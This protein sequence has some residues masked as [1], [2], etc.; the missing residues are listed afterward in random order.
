M[1]SKAV[2]LLL[3][4]W[5]RPARADGPTDPP[6]KGGTR[7]EALSL[8]TGPGSLQGM[9]E[10]LNAEPSTGALTLTVP[11]ALPP[12]PHGFQ[13][14]LS[15][16]YASR[17]GNG[18]LGLGWS[19]AL[20][21]ISRRTDHGLP[22]YAE[23]RGPPNDELLWMGRRLIQVDAD[24]WRLRVEGEF[25]RIV[26]LG[27][28]AAGFRADRKDGSKIFLGTSAASQVAQGGRIFRWLPERALDPFGNE[29][30]YRYTWDEGQAY[31]EEVR[32]GTEGAPHARA[33]LTY[34]PRPDVQVDLRSGFAVATARRLV[35]IETFVGGD[36]GLPVRHVSL[37][38][39]AGPGVSRLASVQTC[40]FDRATC[41]PALTFG[42]TG[43]DPSLATL[44]NL[45]PP[46][47]TL[48]DPN[49]AL[50]DVDGDSLPDVVDLTEQGASVFRNLGPGGF[51]SGVALSGAPGVQLSSPGVAFQ[52]MD[53]DGHA[54]LLLA[55]GATGADGFAYL[56]AMG[57]GLGRSVAVAA[58]F[59]LPASAGQLRWIDL[60]GDGRVDAL[61]GQ[62]EGWTAW[63][64]L[65][66]GNFGDALPVRA[67]LAN[68][69]LDDAR[70]R[71][72]DMNDDG[73]VD[74]VLLQ[75]GSLQVMFNQ[76]FGNFS[77]PQAMS[78]VPDV[79]GDDQRLAL[80][81]ADGDGLPDLYY[82]APGRLLLWLNR[83]DGTFGTEVQARNAPSYDP[84][85]TTV[86][87][88][89]LLGN[90]T[91]G[92]VY[93]GSQDGKPFLWFF[94]PSSGQRPNL[95]AVID[96]G[97]GGKRIVSYQSTGQAMAAAAAAG[98]G[99]KSFTPFAQSIV[100]SVSLDDGVSPSE[101]E[102]RRYANPHYDGA[103]RLF[104]G[105]A[106]EARE[107]PQ[108]AHAAG[109]LEETLFHTGLNEDLSLVGSRVSHSQSTAAGVLLRR[110]TNEVVA[111]A[112]A[113]GLHGES[114]AFA[115]E[116]A[117]T[118][119][120]WEGAGRPLRERRRQSF[121]GHGNV[122]DRFDDGRIDGPPDPAADHHH[123]AF[124]EDTNQWM[125]GLPAVD[126][127]TDASGHRV[128]LE[129][130]YYDGDSCQGLPLGR[131]VRGAQ[132]RREGW[133]AEQGF[134]DVKR[135]ALDDHGN[136]IAW[137]DAD[138]RRVETDYDPILHQFPVEE[139]HFA[140][141]GGTPLRFG[142]AVDPAIGQPLWFRDA[143]GALTRYGWD[144]LGRLVSIERPSDP[145][146]DPGELRRYEL[147][148]G[149]RALE[150]LRRAVPGQPFD[151]EEADLYDGLL[152]PLAHVT[153]AEGGTYA[154]SDRVLRD[155]QGH[156][157]VH[158]VP[159][160]SSGLAAVDP[161]ASTATSE[162]IYD[163]LGRTLRR[164]LPAG[165]ETRQAYGPGSVT[166]FD[167]EA[168]VGAASPQRRWLDWQ[169]RISAIDWDVGGK[170]PVRYSFEIDP[171]GHVLSRQGPVGMIA[172]ARYD[173]LGH[174]VE[175][176]DAD[177]GEVRWTYDG[178]GH[179]VSRRNAAGQ[180]V[181]WTYDGAG[182]VLTEDDDA[183]RRATYR[184]DLK[185]EAA[186]RLGEVDDLSGATT[187]VYDLAGRLTGLGIRQGDVALPMAFSYDEAD[188]LVRVGYPDGQ[189][190][191]YQYG[192]RGLAT[193]IPGLLD[194]ATY[195]AAGQPLARLFNN[196]ALV[197]VGRD[198][199]ERV[200]GVEARFA[201]NATLSMAYELLGSGALLTATD[202]SGRTDFQ[203]DDQER[204][205]AEVSAQGSRRQ[206]YD[207]AGRL[208]SR[209][210]DPADARL[211]GKVVS[212]GHNAG[213]DAL[214]EDE[215][216]SYRYDA[217][218]QRVFSR[219]LALGYDPAGHLTSVAGAS[220]SATYAYA[221]NGERR[222]RKV[223]FAD[224][225]EATVLD[226]GPWLEVDDGVL[227]KHVHLGADRIASMSGDLGLARTRVARAGGQGGCSSGGGAPTFGPL[228]LAWL[229][230]RRRGGTST[231]TRC[232]S[233]KSWQT[234]Q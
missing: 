2:A 202:E 65:G 30:V 129:R 210:A 133:I 127:L 96:N 219:G 59:N 125:L 79:Q 153:S 115:A 207:P 124:A 140:S 13:P 137:L 171:L 114:A 206:S 42:L 23:G 104:E 164:K 84:L 195:D 147:G 150:R 229:L 39:V 199:A 155:V 87:F 5:A 225:R 91:R 33:V 174:L 78:G 71:L 194:A 52:D 80:G 142:I 20:A 73:L 66:G 121:D 25:T 22:R 18:P 14:D 128:A 72:A 31:L 131:V 123:F 112:V 36:P 117:T 230:V 231:P 186:G 118:R 161:P 50:V 111:Q 214:T 15:L 177:A 35:A 67:P 48:G 44:Q 27:G 108:D 166:I 63:L 92:V 190:L 106:W 222:S 90:G 212:F 94:D 180:T 226:F 16:H 220:V 43:R 181:R 7:P 61:L 103:E 49:V 55:L 32:Y 120:L 68:L 151:L 47:V 21:E 218:G 51:A 170:Q 58:P 54:D 99:W 138:G 38:Y 145:T 12:G 81:D 19:L 41:L 169:E 34:E 197:Q 233:P 232:R 95:L 200:V 29:I 205:F 119:E 178:M 187:Y 152:R 139:R 17:A 188:R 149:L 191:T 88:V 37:T 64:N 158:F 143:G 26:S 211:P 224:G 122:T 130:R 97:M 93:S 148:A 136:A 134:V 70:V 163:A 10:T 146:G 57:S 168:A 213:P 86:R 62:A 167:A 192:L 221:F 1:R 228:A 85:S 83:G 141:Q 109:L 76:G 183:G 74:V 165:G 208:L 45:A 196:G 184:Y 89:D 234:Q 156:A 160:F 144:A 77:A 126:E 223:G 201:M 75:S 113:T 176:V 185:P 110:T 135:T 6:D 159:F 40:G 3:V 215:G 8:P 182:R 216:G 46:G 9:G 154:V 69:A 28:A 157:A 217:M 193:A 172:T 209:T 198:A 98:A 175:L 189:A 116:S 203:I 162:E 24:T 105:F 101:T 179:P 56:P 132:V 102:V 173:G 204:L 82:V 107:L 100:A 11:V 227:W 4:F 53:G 60:D